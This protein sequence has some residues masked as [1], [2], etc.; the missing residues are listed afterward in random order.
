MPLFNAMSDTSATPT[1]TPVPSSGK[2]LPSVT[3][4]LVDLV[5]RQFSDASRLLTAFLLGALLLAAMGALSL[6]SIERMSQRV[7][8]LETL[9]EKVDGGRQMEYQVTAQSHYRAMAL[10]T[11]DDA[12]NVKIADAKQAITA[13]LTR[14]QA[15][16]GSDSSGF[17]A[18]F[19]EAD[20][21]F[22]LS[23]ERVLALYRLGDID[24]A[25]QLHLAEE[26]PI[27]HV[28]EA[29]IREF[30][31]DA[32]TEMDN[33]R[34]AFQTDRGFLTVSVIGFSIAA[35]TS[36]LILGFVLS[37]EIG[38]RITQ[39]RAEVHILQVIIDE[40]RRQHEVNE[41]VDSEFFVDLSKRAQ[42][43]RARRQ[44][45]GRPAS[46]DAPEQAS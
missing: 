29:D 1:V 30:E 12:N 41:I 28:L 27:S 10:L 25:M 3:Q 22:D 4:P 21:R 33:A 36:A 17:F 6:V 45:R 34:Q 7:G 40:T 5:R 46:E 37:R 35:L 9:Q 8:E 24:A 18:K 23:S 42:M 20:R 14:L 19:A 39:L 26:H 15:L 43:M 13:H 31:R 32:S 44:R 11:N 16:G 38:G 2:R